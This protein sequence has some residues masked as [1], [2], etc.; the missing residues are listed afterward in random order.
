[1]SSGFKLPELKPCFLCPET[2][3]LSDGSLRHILPWDCLS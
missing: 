3:P 2:Y 1:M